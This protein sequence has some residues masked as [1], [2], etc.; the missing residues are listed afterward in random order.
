MITLNAI[1]KRLEEFATNHYF[2]RSYS[3]GSPDD[4]DLEKFQAFP[5][6][7]VVYTGATYDGRLKTYSFEVY[8]FDR[9]NREEQMTLNQREI[10]SDA[11]Q[12]LEDIV[13]DIA[14]GGNI[15]LF[16]EDYE[17]TG[18]SVSPLVDERSNLLSGALLDLAIQVPY[19]RDACNLPVN[20]VQP[21]GGQTSYARRGILR[22]R[23]LNGAV[24]VL[25]VNEIRVPNGTLTDDGGG[26]VTLDMS[27]SGGG[28]VNSV[29]GQTGDVVLDADDIDDTATA[30]K[31]TDAAGLTKLGFISVTGAVNLDDM[32]TD[33]EVAAAVGVEEAAR[34]A[35]DTALQ[36]QITTNASDIDAAEAALI[37]EAN[38][39]AAADTALQGVINSNTSAI[40]TEEA[41]RIAGD[42]NLQSQISANDS[43]ITALGG[44]MTT[45]E[46][47]IDALQAATHVN[48]LNALTGAVTLSAG[49]NVTLT[50][51]GNDIEIASS[52]GG[53]GG[54][55]DSFNTIA[56]PG[57]SNI[58]ADHGNDTLNITAGNGIA[59]TTTPAS[60][61][62]NIAVD[63]TTTEIPEG[64]NLYYTSAR[65]DARIAAASVT[66]LADVTSAGSGAIITSAER[67]KLSG[68]AAGAE[69]NV[70]ADWTAASGDAQILNKP[71]IPTDLSDLTGDT[72]DV[73][74]GTNLYFTEARVGAYLNAN[75]NFSEAPVTQITGNTTLTD[76]HAN[77]FL[78][79]INGGAI[80][81]SISAGIRR[82][83]EI[84]VMQASTGA[85][86]IAAG[87]GVTLR[88]TT[89]FT[90]LTAEQYALVGLKQL[91]TTDVWV[92]TGE[93]KPA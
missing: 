89:P 20:G 37:A 39:R 22:V 23:T 1:A 55:S 74:E 56:V 65:V 81:L 68:I 85:V 79:C 40:A 60:D 16:T 30:H 57:Q 17:V 61:T 77:R 19:Q 6:M 66:N 82:S 8:V 72:G 9:P 78:E 25:S 54:G 21:E 47:E 49:A 3:F 71:T 48:S 12:C 13:A 18:A 75:L 76:A 88:N 31:F 14:N 35:A 4:V 43:D 93:R 34:I 2:I 84:V 92:I 10:V 11:E 58:V 53:G 87:A 24:D 63:A 36:G 33:A 45:A 28:A 27:G 86:T 59:L 67:T 83:A 90:N 32:A 15:F 51:V 7:H 64:T 91:G 42:S 46:S 5:L 52:G 29:N 62:L 26:A 41:A 44:R 70:N 69:V 73:P 38:T 80:T 50:Q